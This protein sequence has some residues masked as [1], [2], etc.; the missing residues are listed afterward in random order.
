MPVIGLLDAGSPELRM[1]HGHRMLMSPVIAS[2]TSA[3][4]GAE[5]GH[6]SLLRPSSAQ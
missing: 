2:G 4:S 5:R 1:N 6:S 3:N